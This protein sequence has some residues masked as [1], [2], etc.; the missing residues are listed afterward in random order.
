M[1][2][3]EAER[4]E[5]RRKHSHSNSNCFTWDTTETTVLESAGARTWDQW[6]RTG[7]WGQQSENAAAGALAYTV[8]EL[9]WQGRELQVEGRLQDSKWEAFQTSEGVAKASSFPVP[10]PF[11]HQPE[12][13][14]NNELLL[15]TYKSDTK[16]MHKEPIFC[17]TYLLLY[18]TSSLAEVLP[19]TRGSN[20]FLG[21]SLL[22]ELLVP[23]Q[24]EL[25]MKPPLKHRESISPVL[26]V[27]H[28]RFI[29]L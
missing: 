13:R 6:R 12:Y 9:M 26:L 7:A 25:K 18:R 21:C 19:V 5:K 24:P 27:T 11:L 8:P 4:Q 17:C 29:L 22:Q 2:Q 3:L 23:A 10:C 28:C 14:W 1:L 15:R 16:S 20:L